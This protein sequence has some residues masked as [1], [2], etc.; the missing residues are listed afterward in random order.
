MGTRFV[1]THECDAA[2][3]FKQAYINA[4]EADIIITTSPV[5]LPGRAL[6]NPFLDEAKAGIPKGHKCIVNC[7]K[8][9]TFKIS[10]KGYCIATAL[11]NAQQG[12]V[13]HGLIFTGSNATRCTKIVS[14]EDIFRDLFR[15]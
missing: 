11:H 1:C 10:K 7:L 12:D 14:V 8:N 6:R 13:D 5:G 3:E 2:D 15:D 9:C 4:T